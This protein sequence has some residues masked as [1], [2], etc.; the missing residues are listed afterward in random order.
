MVYVFVTC[1]F[2]LP[3]PVLHTSAHGSFALRFTAKVDLQF[4]QEVGIKVYRAVWIYQISLYIYKVA[5]RRSYHFFRRDILVKLEDC[6]DMF[7]P[8]HF[9]NVYSPGLKPRQKATRNLGTWSNWSVSST[10]LVHINVY[11]RVFVY[12]SNQILWERFGAG[13]ATYLLFSYPCYLEHN[14]IVNPIGSQKP[15]M[16]PSDFWRNH[17]LSVRNKRKVCSMLIN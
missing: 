9:A 10:K 4:V 11:P 16:T 13:H 12:Y 6:V 7:R 14:W 17:P 1:N 8:L 15:W 3:H 5:K 2:S